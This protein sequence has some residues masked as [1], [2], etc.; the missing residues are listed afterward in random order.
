M[1]RDRNA[2]EGSIP[3]TQAIMNKCKWCKSDYSELDANRYCFENHLQY[4]WDSLLYCSEEF[5]KKGRYE[6]YSM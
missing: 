5:C 2:Q 4:H 1:V 6:R 3:S